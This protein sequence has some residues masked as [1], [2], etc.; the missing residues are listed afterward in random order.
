MG[1]NTSSITAPTTPGGPLPAGVHEHFVDARG[2][3]FRYLKGGAH[4]HGH[5]PILFIHGWPSWAEVWLPVA[6]QIGATHP[7]IAV[8]LPGHYKSS[9]LPGNEGS[10]TA[11]RRA[12]SAFLDAME[13]KRF[14]VVGCSIGGTLGVMMALDRP[15][16]VERA[17]NGHLLHAAPLCRVV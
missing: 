5:A 14:S 1:D 9:P 16:D 11:L 2:V 15:Q 4:E 13:L 6:E 10:L 8:D 7:W 12:M 3:R 17:L